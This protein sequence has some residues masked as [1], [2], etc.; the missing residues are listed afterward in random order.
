MLEDVLGRHVSAIEDWFSD[1]FTK[2]PAVLSTSVDVRSSGYKIAPVDVN[3]FPAGYNN[4]GIPARKKAAAALSEYMSQYLDTR[5]LIVVEGH[6]RNK[7][8]VDSV[9]ALRDML[10]D[11]GF[12]AEVGVCGITEDTSVLSSTGAGL[13]IKA[14]VNHGGEVSTTSG[15]VP[16]LIILNSDLTS[17]VPSVLDG[18][19]TQRVIPPTRLG[20]FNRRKSR[21]FSIYENVAAEFCK[22]FGLDE[23]GV[24]A[25]FMHC[26]DVDFVSKK[27]IDHI[28]NK[29]EDLISQI[30]EKFR[31]YGIEGA[32]HVFVKA[33]NGTYGMGVIEVY[34]GDD[35]LNMNKRNRNKMRRIK[36]NNPVKSVMLQEGIPT[37][38]VFDG[39]AAEPLLYY[40]GSEPVCYLCRYNSTK[41]KFENLNAPGCGFADVELD[42]ACGKKR[43]WRVIGKLAVLASAIE[44]AEIT[45]RSSHTGDQLP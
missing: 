11:S 9:I 7:K 21:H 1:R 17:G 45:A 33:D 28:A 20:W 10:G 29:V 12:R 37:D 13:D 19:L 22:E 8:Y 38:E 16:D 43:V 15:F 44:A 36:D 23:W 31:L 41:S 34:S 6:T 35:V 39:H 30:G 25:L 40:V 14:L 2:Y 3:F 27:G 5:V 42:V 32:P 4:F 24:C 26:Q 18:A